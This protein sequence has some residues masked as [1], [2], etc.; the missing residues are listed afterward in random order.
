MLILEQY[1]VTLSRL[2][3]QDLEL[4]R[5]WRNQQDVA[6][7]M[8]Y[9]TYITPQMQQEWFR[10][11]NNPF[12][13]YFIIG[14]DG[15]KTGLINAKD[16]NPTLE[17]GEG[18]IFIW[19]KDYLSS[20]VPVFSSLCLLNF[21]LLKV[22]MFSRSRIRIMRQ[23]E[24]AI[25]YNKLLGYTLLPGQDNIENQ[26]YELSTE[27]YAVKSVRLNKAAAILSGK[28]PELRYSGS[29]GSENMDVVNQL[30]MSK[31]M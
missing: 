8:A 14:Y 31:P 11:V 17:Y 20:H 21:A 10:S 7:H 6:R 16:Y 19:D 1:G 12:N 28:G 25:H 3:S 15:K 23:N 5:Y 29:V 24:R 13:Y 9:R 30:L 27:T 4:V 2:T 18:G 22:K 26:V